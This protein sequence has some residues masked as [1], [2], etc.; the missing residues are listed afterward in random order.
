MSEKRRSAAFSSERALQERLQV[1]DFIDR[2]DWSAI[3]F[4]REVPIGGVIPDL[5]CLRFRAI[6][7]IKPNVGR[8]SYRHAHLLWLLRRW[9]KLRLPSLVRLTYDRE[10]NVRA[11]IGDLLS[12]GMLVQSPSGA[13]A[14]S[15]ELSLLEAEV[16]A[17]EAKLYHWSQA[18]KQACSYQHFADR[19]FVAMDYE[20]I[21]GK[22]VPKAEFSYHGVGLLGVSYDGTTLLNRSRKRRQNSPEREYLVLSVLYNKHY[23]LWAW[24]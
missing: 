15:Q 18:L 19:V 23:K 6:P 14:L 16:I 3:Y 7:Q 2:E 22:N 17:I 4:R 13:F 20:R 10:N 12:Q 24:Q 8:W 9:K 1:S 5:V 11:L 21:K